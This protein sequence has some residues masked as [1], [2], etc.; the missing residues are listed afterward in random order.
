MNGLLLTSP[1]E[2]KD[3]KFNPKKLSNTKDKNLQ[4]SQDFLMSLMDN[5]LQDIP[6]GQNKSFFIAKILDFPE[7]FAKKEEIVS[8]FSGEQLFLDHQIDKVSVEDLLIV[9]SFLKSNPPQ[10]LNFPTDSQP[11]QTALLDLNVQ[12]E[13]KNAK[14]VGDLLK[15]A[16]KNGIKIKNFEFFKEEAALDTDT[17]KLVQRV[18]SGEI[19]QLLERQT[20]DTKTIKAT[21]FY[22]TSIQQKANGNLLKKLLVEHKTY[23]KA[24][25]TISNSNEHIQPTNTNKD[26]KIKKMTISHTEKAPVKTVQQQNSQP[27][28]QP[29]SILQEDASTE[30]PTLNKDSF[31]QSQSTQKKVSPNILNTILH[32]SVPKSTDKDLRKS[33]DNQSPQ[34]SSVAK[35]IHPKT[36]V[37]QNISL[38]QHSPSPENH[39]QPNTKNRENSAIHI[40]ESPAP[41]HEQPESET[42]EHLSGEKS[43]VSHETKNSTPTSSKNQHF[44]PQKTFHTFAEEFKE[45]VESYKPPLMKI[46]MQLNPGNLGDVDVTLINRGNN[47]QVNINSTPNTIALFVQNQAEFKNALVNMG[48]TGLQMNFGENREGERGQQQ[49]KQHTKKSTASS[50]ELHETD[51]FEMI[52]PRYI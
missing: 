12:H 28:N 27:I 24:Q 48:F 36:T 26:Q 42:I 37:T 18:K 35:E 2:N 19:F 16:E 15:I 5:L 52:V 20:K 45:K 11:F 38:H 22:H 29:P 51:G 47:L 9:A 14:T 13:F 49:P 44:H 23:A 21:S 30:T 43:V 10:P 25:Q 39:T 31:I 17:K 33:Q 1:I 32:T 3:I 46:K 8:S 50:E 40:T 7:D 34:K 4:N 41:R 6:D